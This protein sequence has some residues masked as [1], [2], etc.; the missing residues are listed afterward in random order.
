M[1]RRV[2]A[3]QAILVVSLSSFALADGAQRIV[4]PTA[5][6]RSSWADALGESGSE[7]VSTAGDGDEFWVPE[8]PAFRHRPDRIVQ[9]ESGV[10]LYGGFG[11]R[12][13]VEPETVQHRSDG[14][15]FN[16][17]T[18]AH[19]VTLT[20]DI[21]A[22]KGN[23]YSVPIALNVSDTAVLDGFVITGGTHFRT[24]EP[25]WACCGTAIR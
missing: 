22:G 11:K 4:T 19:G 12:D 18:D 14:D 23:S 1:E 13:G 7:R 3:I 20:D 2:S 25:G 16:D 24:A 17:T 8:V 10:S 5:P 15:G 9:S 6:K 21:T